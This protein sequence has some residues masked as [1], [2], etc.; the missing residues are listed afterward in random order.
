MT[1]AILISGSVFKYWFEYEAKALI[2]EASLSLQKAQEEREEASLSLQKAQEERKEKQ[3]LAK[4]KHDKKQ[5]ILQAKR[6]QERRASK[7][8]METCTFWQKQ[9]VK[10]KTSYEK[11]MMNTACK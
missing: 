4:I 10:Y 5:R 3:R 2:E 8:K 1:F 11:R 6:E 9:Y 7:A